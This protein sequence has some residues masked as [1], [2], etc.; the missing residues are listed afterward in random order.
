MK[1][2]I[3][4]AGVGSRL[5]PHTNTTPKPLME[6]AGKPMVNYVIDDVLKLNPTEIIFIVG[7]KKESIIL[8]IK[9]NYPNIN[10]QFVEQTI[11]NGDGAA[12][13]LGL[14]DINKEEE[15]YIVIGDT[16][17]DFDLKKSL[18][19][20]KNTDSVIFAM[21]VLT[22]E[23]YGVLNVNDNGE[24]YEVEEKPKKAKSNLAIIGSYYFKSLLEVKKILNE[25]YD[26][27]ETEK[28]EFRLVQVIK[29]YIENKNKTI[30]FSQVK[31]WFDCGRVEVLL[32]A[33]K[34]F[35]E[36]KSSGQIS[37]KKDCIIIP[38][39]YVSKSAK[40]NNCIIGPYVSIGD[41]VEIE[42]SR[43]RNSIVNSNTK[44]KSFLLKDSLIGK[45]VILIGK[46][47]KINLGEK[48]EVMFE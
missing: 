9:N 33:N 13:R 25:I 37:T 44:I 30:K 17:I 8:H 1:V 39:S 3:P 11:R 32:D 15:L 21:K 35:L 26:K 23:N 41:N 7:Y 31:E 5:K 20:E 43:I 38:P 40:L 48:S 36:K 10:S 2:I 18:E 42:N 12:V 22:P 27:N 47:N 14:K 16:L 29:K 28:G 34:Y 46:S 24:I 19:K 6:V 45:E 4:V